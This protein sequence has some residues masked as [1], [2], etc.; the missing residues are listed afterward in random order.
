M[1]E[2][3]LLKIIDGEVVRLRLLGFLIRRCKCL[4]YE[5]HIRI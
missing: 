1:C 3:M 5:R 2:L 4:P